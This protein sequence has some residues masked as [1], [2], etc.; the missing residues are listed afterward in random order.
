MKQKKTYL[1]KIIWIILFCSFF[2]DI[3][4]IPGTVISVYRMMI[5]IALIL[6]IL[7]FKDVWDFIP[8]ML[9]AICLLVIQNIFFCSVL[10]IEDN[11]DLGWQFQYLLHYA[12]IIVIFILV[13]ILRKENVSEFNKLLL[14][15][16]SVISYLNI[17]AYMFIL[18]P[19]AIGF[20]FSNRNN[21]AASLVAIFP[22]HFLKALCGKWKN[23]L[24]CMSIF[25]SCCIF[26]KWIKHFLEIT[27]FY[28]MI[29][30]PVNYTFPSIFRNNR[31]T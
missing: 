7:C 15:L 23:T 19:Y 8:V 21:Y 31:I 17:F 24:I 26:I 20:N 2:N 6:A 18:T 16:T 27:R 4:R 12:G 30:N 29:I 3:L 14:R 5:P 28:F 11:V 13:R 25:I 1:S 22:W 10:K 9:I